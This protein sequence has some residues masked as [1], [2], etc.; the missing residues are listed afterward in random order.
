M[1]MFRWVVFDLD[2]DL[3]SYLP[4]LGFRWV[5]WWISGFGL[6]LH[7]WIS[8]YL[9]AWFDGLFD[10]WSWIY[11]YLQSF[12]SSWC[13]RDSMSFLAYETSLHI[14]YTREWSG[15]GRSWIGYLGL[16]EV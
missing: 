13:F 14:Y 11:C 8:F 15:L 2:M 4:E 10:I 1:L 7:G 16:G 6:H 12:A 9:G 5:G 3:G